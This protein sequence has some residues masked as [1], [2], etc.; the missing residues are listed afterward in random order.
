MTLHHRNLEQH[1]LDLILHNHHSLNTVLIH[2]HLL[3][4][5]LH[6]LSME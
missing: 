1:L 2:L 6:K 3:D 4:N 5:T